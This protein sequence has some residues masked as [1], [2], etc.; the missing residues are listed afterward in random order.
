MQG[1]CV[2]QAA[3]HDV[4]VKALRCA[5]IVPA[6]P[7]SAELSVPSCSRWESAFGIGDTVWS[8]WR[9]TYDALRQCATTSLLPPSSITLPEMIALDVQV[10]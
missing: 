7:C 5:I 6:V 1:V 4:R 2:V 10:P 3:G 9:S 8:T